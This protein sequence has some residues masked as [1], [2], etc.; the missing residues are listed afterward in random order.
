MEGTVDLQVADL[1]HLIES[2][3]LSTNEDYRPME[4]GKKSSYFTLDVISDLA[5]GKAFGYLHE[6]KDVYNY[7]EMMESSIPLMMLVANIPSLA[8]ILQSRL[9]R[10]LL[11]S[12]AD[13]V[14]FGAFIGL[15]SLILNSHR[16][17]TRSQ[18]SEEA[19]SRTIQSQGRVS[20]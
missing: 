14:G 17:L 7:I 10:S 11:P 13:K 18:S 20:L 12:E 5:F 2:K 8:D 4:F 19:R 1:I 6:D 15:V 16:L 3:Y 9:L